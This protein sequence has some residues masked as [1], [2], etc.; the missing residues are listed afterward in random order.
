M[1]GLRYSSLLRPVLSTHRPSTPSALRTLHSR[2]PSY[3]FS[4]PSMSSSPIPTPFPSTPYNPSSSTWPYTASD[5]LRHDETSDSAFYLHPRLVTHIDDAAI[6]R[7]TAYYDTV[8][9]TTGRIMDMC[10]SWKSFYPSATTQAIQRGDV[11]VYGVGLNAEEM[12]MNGALGE[13][14]VVDL[15]RAPWD[16]R[17]GWEG[18]EEVIGGFDAVTCVVSVDYLNRPLEVCRNLLGAVREGGR[19]HFV[20]SNRCFPS[21][22]VR[23]WMVLEERGRL[24]FVGGE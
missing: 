22:V 23:R 3:F 21:K 24:E 20:V 13:W 1:S 14:R 6:A 16:V 8:L 4:T 11:Q 19:V 17:S 7:L 12:G 9:P 18:E 15:N 10:T 2:L 5:F